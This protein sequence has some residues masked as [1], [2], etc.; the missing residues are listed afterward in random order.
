LDELY[1][2][3]LSH[4]DRRE[5]T[6]HSATPSPLNI[7]RAADA[8]EPD[9]DVSPVRTDETDWGRTLPEAKE[10]PSAPMRELGREWGFWP[11]VNDVD[12]GV[13]MGTGDLWRGNNS[14]FWLLRWTWHVAPAAA[15]LPLV[16]VPCGPVIAEED[17][18]TEVAATAFF[19]FFFEETLMTE[20]VKI[21][22]PHEDDMLCIGVRTGMNLTNFF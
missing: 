16:T 14:L 9:Q 7:G 1:Y 22:S 13:V 8:D 4:K 2:S 5:D 17:A 11:M 3:S 18:K 19:F 20:V 15:A 6:I 10:P 12:T 21:S